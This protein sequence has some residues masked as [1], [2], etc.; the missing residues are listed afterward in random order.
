LGKV[1][2]FADGFQ[3]VRDNHNGLF[4]TRYQLTLNS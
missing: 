1:F 2:F 4:I 3:A